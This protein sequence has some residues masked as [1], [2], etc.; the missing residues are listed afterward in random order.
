MEILTLE[1]ILSFTRDGKMESHLAPIGKVLGLVEHE[2]PGRLF[3]KKVTSSGVELIDGTVAAYPEFTLDVFNILLTVPT[4]RVFEDEVAKLGLDP[5][6]IMDFLRRE[7]LVLDL[8]D[9][10]RFD[11]LALL[12][13]IELR[14]EIN[15]DTGYVQCYSIRGDVEFP[16][17]AA[18]VAVGLECNNGMSLLDSIDYSA[19]LNGADPNHIAGF[20]ISELPKVVGSLAGVIQRL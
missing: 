12:L 19:E 6:E 4:V 11:E 18:T 14:S 7:D 16:V 2:K 5:S 13:D 17:Q 15:Y 9:P 3:K 10:S 20:I 8:P 1:K